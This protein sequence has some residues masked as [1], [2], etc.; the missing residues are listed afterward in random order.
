[1]GLEPGLEFHRVECLLRPGDSLLLYTDG[2]NE[3]F[4]PADECYGNDRLIADLGPLSGQPAGSL[5]SVLCDQVRTFAAGAPQSDD[6]TV[7]A[8]HLPTRSTQ[9]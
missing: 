8:L 7:L 2:V 9:P 4:N 3:A 6:I 5:V 1:L